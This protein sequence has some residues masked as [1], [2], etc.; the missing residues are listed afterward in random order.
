MGRDGYTYGGGGGCGSVYSI[1]GTCYMILG[2]HPGN[3][4]TYGGGG[5][6]GS[7]YANYFNLYN[8]S[9]TEGGIGGR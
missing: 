3:G 7:M 4:G 2:Y 5:G 6:V 9:M 1:G 8:Y